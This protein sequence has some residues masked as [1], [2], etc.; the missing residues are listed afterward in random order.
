PIRC[1]L[2]GDINPN[3]E[4]WL[5]GIKYTSQIFVRECKK[6]GIRFQSCFSILYILFL[7]SPSNTIEFTLL[8]ITISLNSD[9]ISF[10]IL[11]QSIAISVLRDQYVRP[12]CK[13]L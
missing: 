10:I 13:S 5:P 2:L 4:S 8:E 7:I 9:S 6:L 1:T 12:I 11:Y 3:F